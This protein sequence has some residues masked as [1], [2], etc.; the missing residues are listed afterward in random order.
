MITTKNTALWLPFEGDAADRGVNSFPS[1]PTAIT[2]MPWLGGKAALLNGT[3]SN[4]E[5]LNSASMIQ[6][7]STTTFCCWVLFNSV[8]TSQLIFS[9]R[10]S[11][12]TK[13]FT[14]GLLS[15][16]KLFWDSGD[17]NAHRVSSIS[18]LSAGVWYFVAFRKSSTLADI[19]ISTSSDNSISTTAANVSEANNMFIGTSVNKDGLF[20]NAAIKNAQIYNKSLTDN[21]LLRVKSGLHPLF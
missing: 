10:S 3:S 5:I 8:T 1:I 21:N 2:Y 11:V 19:F 15:T 13:G 14:A 7:L 16:G 4:V 6:S 18:T 17:G 9:N 12:I 20:L